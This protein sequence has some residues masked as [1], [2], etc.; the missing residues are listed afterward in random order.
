MLVSEHSEDVG[1]GVRTVTWQWQ[2]KNKNDEV[3]G[4]NDDSAPKLGREDDHIKHWRLMCRQEARGAEDGKSM[5]TE[6]ECLEQTKHIHCHAREPK[7]HY[8]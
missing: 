6:K 7:Q 2:G 1:G 5:C 3:T 8:C 4:S